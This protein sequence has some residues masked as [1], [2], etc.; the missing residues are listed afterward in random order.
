VN[1]LVLFFIAVAAACTGFKEQH[2]LTNDGVHEPVAGDFLPDSAY[3]IYERLMS[4]QTLKRFYAARG[5]LLFWSKSGVLMPAADSLITR[6]AQADRLGLIPADYHL[7]EIRQQ[8]A[9]DTLSVDRLARLDLL[10]TDSYVTLYRHVT[11]GRLDPKTLQRVDLSTLEDP[12]A[13]AS[14]A[15]IMEGSI[16]RELDAVEPGTENYRAMKGALMSVLSAA[17]RDSV[18]RQRAEKM[19]LNLERWRWEKAWPDRCVY[20]N[21]PA[22][23]LRVFE[24]DSVWLRSRVIVGKRETPTPVLESVIRSF[25]IYPYWHVPHSISTKEILPLLQRDAAYLRRNNFEVLNGSGSVV[26][27]DT[28]QW[29]LYKSGRFPFTLRQREGSENS[30][31]IIKFNFSNGYGVY[32]HDTN[33]K[34]L[35]QR[36]KRDLSHGCV[37]IDRAV[38]LAHYLVR[39][40]DIYVSPEDLDQYLS[41]QQRYTIDLRKPI[42]LKM[43]Y[44]TAEIENGIPVFYDDIYKKD[45]VMMRSLYRHESDVVL[46]SRSL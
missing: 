46:R 23:V 42:T 10:L 12:E 20:V 40:D 34:R 27:A 17:A 2:P 14:M 35:Y 33:S 8:L 1:K 39:E 4:R 18:Q 44:F 31:G 26:N 7:D 16:S 28:I 37:R 29:A 13:I 9:T 19:A 21:I 3:L 5:S 32:L 38:G 41:L 30:M 25:I 45:S 11:K 43:G 22:F 15:R 36:S 24:N 6:I